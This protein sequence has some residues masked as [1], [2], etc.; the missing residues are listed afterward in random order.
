MCLKYQLAISGFQSA[1]GRVCGGFFWI[2]LQTGAFMFRSSTCLIIFSGVKLNESSCHSRTDV[3]ER[4]RRKLLQVVAGL[5]ARNKWILILLQHR[6]FQRYAWNGNSESSAALSS[7]AQ[8]AKLSHAVQNTHQGISKMIHKQSD[9]ET[10]LQR[11]TWKE[12]KKKQV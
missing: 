8:T 9:R 2:I 7:E 4:R 1:D 12:F 5:R 11:E 10:W 3:E 6:D